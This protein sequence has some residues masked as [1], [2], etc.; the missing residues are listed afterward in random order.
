MLETILSLYQDSIRL[1][2]N[3]LDRLLHAMRL[4]IMLSMLTANYIGYRRLHQQILL[5]HPS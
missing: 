4:K 5:Y 2:G 3:A 1:L